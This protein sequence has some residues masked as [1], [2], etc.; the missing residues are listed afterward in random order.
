[1]QVVIIPGTLSQHF[2]A[3]ESE[4]RT[5]ARSRKEANC[6]CSPVPEASLLFPLHTSRAVKT[7]GRMLS[8]DIVL[9][10]STFA[11][12][13]YRQGSIEADYTIGNFVLER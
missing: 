6:V 7:N 1:M 12:A 9:C 4:E 8:M 3:A 11:S 10:C 5:E 2:I 13:Y